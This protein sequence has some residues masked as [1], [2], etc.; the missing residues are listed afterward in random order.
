MKYCVD[1]GTKLINR[2]LEKEGIIPYCPTC[3]KH[4]FPTFNS[5]ISTVIFNASKDK[6]LLIQQYHKKANI[7]VAG[8][9]NKGENA[10]EAL[11][12][13]VKEEVNLDIKNYIYNDNVYYEKTN[14]LIHNYTSFVKDE[15]FTLTSEVDFAKWYSIEEAIK[16]IKEKSLAKQ[17][18]FQTLHKQGLSKYLLHYDTNRIYIL[19]AYDQEVAEV[20][21][22]E[23]ADA[24]SINHTFV[25]AS[26]RGLGIA[27]VLMEAV[28]AYIKSK[29]KNVEATCS[30]A[31]HYLEKNS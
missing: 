31:V 29:N 11:V 21:F 20:T 16:V 26:L 8:Y 7:L 14:T 6:I 15:N 18:L 5:A 13:E 12:R 3:Q 24:C 28:I 22:I 17:F 19:D 4:I 25:D 9:I 2:Q 23:K 30:Y 1:C 27:K 10:N